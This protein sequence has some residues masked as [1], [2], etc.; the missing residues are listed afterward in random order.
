MRNGAARRS[1]GH[2]Y[3]S[4]Q[5][6]RDVADGSSPEQHRRFTVPPAARTH[7]FHASL[8]ATSATIYSS[9]ARARSESG[10]VRR[11][12]LNSPLRPASTNASSPVTIRA[13]RTL[14]AIRP[15]TTKGDSRSPG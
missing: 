8:P 15:R 14:S 2:P 10:T 6:A 13:P 9:T 12:A 5:H 1:R 11:A 7:T 4:F 3:R